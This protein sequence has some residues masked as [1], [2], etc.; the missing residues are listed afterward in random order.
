MRSAQG[1]SGIGNQIGILRT[2]PKVDAPAVAR[3]RSQD[4]R[5]GFEIDEVRF[6]G[7][8]PS[9]ERSIEDGPGLQRCRGPQNQCQLRSR[10]ALWMPS[11]PTTQRAST[12]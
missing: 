1:R 8:G 11:Q 4:D 12:W 10:V 9:L 2:W 3:K 7:V 6:E 5:K